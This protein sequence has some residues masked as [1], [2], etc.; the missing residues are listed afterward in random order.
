MH[1]HTSDPADAATHRGRL[2]LVLALVLGLLAVEVTVVLATGSL[3]LLSDAGH[4]ATDVV[5]LGLSLT[6]INVAAARTPAARSSFGWHR[7]EILAALLNAL[8]LLGIAAAVLITTIRRWDDPHALEPLPLLVV[9]TV[10][11]GVNLLCAR[12]LRSGA[13]TS[14]NLEGARL[15]V[16]ADAVGSIGVLVTAVVVALT[17]WTRIDSLIALAI[18]G[19][20]LPRALRL[21]AR[22]LRILLQHAPSHV[23][24]PA[25]EGALT[26]L[27]D[28][29]D[30]HDLHVW[31]LTSG[32]EVASL[33]AAIRDPARQHETLHAI[34]R[35]VAEHAHTDHVTVQV[36]LVDDPTCCATHPADW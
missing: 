11:L 9:A 10:A 25:L 13:E 32:K 21:A 2:T 29:A 1:E 18:V 3:A 22:S 26:A 15:E 6:A 35:V 17:G 4:L 14:L 30:I 31:T 27:P 28:V 12:L 24:L 5:G 33:H 36:E 8:L 34:K 16:L 20:L 23:D 7:L 19:W